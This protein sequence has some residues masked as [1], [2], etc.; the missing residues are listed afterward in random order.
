MRKQS[1]GSKGEQQPPPPLSLVDPSFLMHAEGGPSGSG[2]GGSGATTTTGTGTVVSPC[3]S[4]SSPES[5]GQSG[6]LTG[7]TGGPGGGGGAAGTSTG[8]SASY[9]SD[10]PIPPPSPFDQP[11]T[12]HGFP[13][14]KV[15]HFFIWVFVLTNTVLFPLLQQDKKSSISS[16]SD[17][18]KP[19]QVMIHSPGQHKPKPAITRK[20]TTQSGQDVEKKIQ[21]CKEENLKHF[22]LI[23]SNLS[24]LP[25]SIRDLTQIT[26]CYL[27]QNKFT[28]LPSEIG[29][30]ENLEFLAI[31]ENSLSSL[32]DSL[33]NLKRLKVLDL[34]H[35]KLNEVLCFLMCSLH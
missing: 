17:T 12:S 20:K 35:N 22:D 32:P 33:A 14:L 26:E 31:N 11:S 7:M 18:A 16:S 34:R 8:T 28:S 27:Y 3:L 5:E 15:V 10:E 25:P 13:S 2:A 4:P 23:K 29:C 24:T 9:L 6:S 1:K 30:L 21:K 19:K